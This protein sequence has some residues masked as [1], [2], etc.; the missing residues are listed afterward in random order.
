MKHLAAFNKIIL[1]K[2]QLYWGIFFL[3]DLLWYNGYS[4]S[5]QYLERCNVRCYNRVIYL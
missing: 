5:V 2:I 4:F 3:E 1:S